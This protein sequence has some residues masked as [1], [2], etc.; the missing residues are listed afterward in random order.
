M[1]RPDIDGL[2]AIAILSVLASHAFPSFLPGGFVGVDVFFVI[3]GFLITRIILEGVE[4]G[5]FSFARFYAHRARRI[6]PALLLV[7]CAVLAAG[8]RFL[9]PGEFAQLGKHVAGGSL[10]VQN[11]VLEREAGYFDVASELKPLLHLWSLAV[12]EQFYLLYPALLWAAWRLRL[13]LL[14]VIAGLGAL[15]FYLNIDGIAAKP[16]SVFFLAHT[17]FW[18]LMAGGLLAYGQRWSRDDE[19]RGRELAAWGGLILICCAAGGMR[20][21]HAFP[22][23]LALAPVTGACLLIHAGPAASVNRWLLAHPLM[24]FVGLI[25]YPLYL[26]HWPLLSFLRLLE[27]DPAWWLVMAMLGLSGLLA[28]LTYQVVERPV[29]AG[30]M[31]RKAAPA[32]SALLLLPATAGVLVQQ[33]GGLPSRFAGEVAAVAAYRYEAGIGARVG[34]C[35]LPADAPAS[36]YSR[37]CLSSDSAASDAIFIWGDSHAARLFSGFAASVGT[38][39]HVAQFTR[40]ACPPVLGLAYP[41]CMAS[42]EAILSIIEEQRPSTVVM[43]AVWGSY[44]PRWQAGSK[45]ASALAATIDRLRHLGVRNVVVAGPAPRWI[46][47][48]P[49]I[50]LNAMNEGPARMTVPERLKTGLDPSTSLLEQDLRHLVQQVSGVTYF[51]LLDTLCNE[52]GCLVRTSRISTSFTTWDQGHLTSEGAGFVVRH[53]LAAISPGRGR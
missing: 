1:Y 6:F 32:L 16:V 22:G 14:A 11:V 48:L 34:L 53:L 4:A 35:W 38:N 44:A 40:D 30:W 8:W 39:G 18:E 27:P 50:A 17:R 52:N 21:S 41:N 13:N 28:W 45:E 33:A 29:R 36:S 12:E 51:S 2:R 37:E 31:G 3:S 9:L 10:F 42:N 19:P 24:V 5:E 23:W 15:S 7:L 25:S 47:D 20:S 46:Q 49:K 43:F 26:W